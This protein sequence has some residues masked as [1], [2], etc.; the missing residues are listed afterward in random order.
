M[1]LRTEEE[2]IQRWIHPEHCVVSICMLTYNHGEY[3]RDA[4]EG[5]LMQETNFA[6]EIL[7]HDDA[8]VDHT[9]SIIREYETR[10]PSIIKPICQTIN[11]HQ[12]GIKISPVYNYPRANGDYVAWCEGDD[13]WIDKSK[14]QTQIDAMKNNPHCHLSFHPAKEIDCSEACG[15]ER[16]IG[17]YAG[18]DEIIPLQ[19][20]MHRKYAM[21]P[22]ASCIITQ[23]AKRE[24]LQFLQGKSYLTLGDLYMQFFGARRGGALYIHRVM[25]IYRICTAHSWTR[26]IKENFDHRLQHELAM[27]KSYR[28]LDIFTRHHYTKEFKLLIIQRIFWLGQMYKKNNDN[29]YHKIYSRF[30]KTLVTQLHNMNSNDEK[31]IIYGAGTGSEFILK[32]LLPEKVVGFLDADSLKDGMKFADK[33]IVSLD[34]ICLLGE[35]KIII[36]L[37]GRSRGVIQNLVKNY[38]VRVENFISF[39]DLLLETYDL[40]DI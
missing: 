2:I 27:I 17:I 31:Y 15:G 20:I 10:Y 19:D 11:Q 18:A 5:I 9:A 8:S 4:L 7:I 37:F 28:E 39:D 32:T 1:T 35:H 33:P 29:R 38:N 16:I 24:L 6:F 26:S 36:S 23:N 34:K 13:C 30:Y 14:L 3:I 22:T 25:S 40:N 21:I 12:L